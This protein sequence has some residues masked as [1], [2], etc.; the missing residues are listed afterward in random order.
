MRIISGGQTGID[1]MGLEV[2]KELGLFT[3]GYAPKGYKT[4]TGNDSSLAGFGLKEHTSTEYNQRTEINVMLSGG[5]IIFGDE[6]SA[7]SKATIKF[8]K[9]H[10]KP[11]LI[12]PTVED[13]KVF[14]K[15]KDIVN[16]AGN[17]ASKLSEE[18]LNLYRETL[19][20]GLS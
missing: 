13:I 17:R 10:Q 7:G 1:R 18:Q 16:I 11:Y 19:K 6:N 9:K 15:T 4:E 8:L 20:Q 12:N 2:A 14:I 3:G 5:T